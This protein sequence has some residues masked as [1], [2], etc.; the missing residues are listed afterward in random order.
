MSDLRDPEFLNIFKDVLAWRR[1]ERQNVRVS[2]ACVEVGQYAMITDAYNNRRYGRLAPG[3]S[4]DIHTNMV[5]ETTQA[6]KHL[7]VKP[8]MRIPD[9]GA[10]RAHLGSERRG[11]QAP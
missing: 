5:W 2:E 8:G 10:E 6:L 4:R 3:E 9:I 1:T 11:R 7:D